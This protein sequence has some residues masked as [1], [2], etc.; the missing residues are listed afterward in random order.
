MKLIIYNNRGSFSTV[1]NA[2][3]E[4]SKDYFEEI[5]VIFPSKFPIDE[6]NYF[7]NVHMKSCDY[8]YILLSGFYSLVDLF[9]K[10][11][12]ND[13]T[14]AKKRNKMNCRYIKEY[15]KTMVIANALY[16]QSRKIIK[17]NYC[18]IGVFSTWYSAN[19]ISAALAKKNFP[20]VKAISYAHSYEVDF[21]KNDFTAIIRDRFKEK[22]LD[23]IFFISK[24]VMEEYIKLN[25]NYLR[26]TEK[27]NALHFG[28]KKKQKGYSRYSKDNV[29]RILTC[30]GISKVKRL[31]LLINALE[32]Y[33]GKIKI[34]WT[35]LGSGD[36]EK[37]IKE[38]ANK[39]RDKDNVNIIFYGHVSN[40]DV[41]LYYIQ[42]R[43]DL[44]LN[45][46]KSEGLPV[47]LMEAMSYGVPVLATDVGGNS[48]IVK[49]GTGFIIDAN[50]T[51]KDLCDKITDIVKNIEM[52]R[53]M[54]ENA[55]NMWNLNFRIDNNVKKLIDEF[56]D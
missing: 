24:N 49:K 39:L 51:A 23:N 15:F 22:Y 36:D 12:I 2:F 53:N 37:R 46:S 10:D 3:L 33:S 44:F 45:I 34:E 50:I 28:S 31:D 20:N 21:R 52:I 25:K 18:N 43:V 27:Y 40:D 32:L 35:H 9:K 13:F 41:H 30:S 1:L 8:K 7:E 48:E 42:N 5:Y 47:S 4:V 11:T 17:K 55:F 19:A 14:Q 38:L 6:Y 54:R 29:F 16:L 26:Y 56:Y